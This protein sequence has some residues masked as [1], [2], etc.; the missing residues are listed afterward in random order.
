MGSGRAGVRAAGLAA[1]ALLGVGQAA[2]QQP[3]QVSWRPA[4]PAQGTLFEVRLDLAKA[5][6][7]TAVQATAAGE[8]LHF[9]TGPDNTLTA[10]A[11]APLGAPDTLMIP[12]ILTQASGAADTVAARIPVSRGRYRMEK[13]TVAPRYGKPLDATTQARVDGE[14]RQALAVSE[15]SHQTPRL[16]NVVVRPRTSRITDGFGGGREFNGRVQS[17]HTGTD[18]AG[19]VGDPVHAAARGVVALVG[20]FYLAG[21]VLYIDHGAGLVSGYFHLSAITVAVGDTVAAGQLIGRVG[22]SG[23]VTGP[24]LHWQLRYGRIS[25]DPMSLLRL[26][27][28][29][30]GEGEGEGGRGTSRFSP[31]PS[32]SPSPSSVTHALKVR[33][34]REEHGDTT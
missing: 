25:V 5:A 22:A 7:P 33:V 12:I 24:H 28:Q 34:R 21:K 20:D 8:P 9:S 23:R 13:L 30:K 11:A 16:W 4:V 6:L 15:Q 3:V 2:G 17:R 32:P 26:E 1:L 10:L 31:S 14:L 29:G 18:F 27:N 19:A